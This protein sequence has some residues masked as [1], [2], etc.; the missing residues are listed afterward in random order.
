[1][2]TF[3]DIALVGGDAAA[4]CVL[5]CERRHVTGPEV[6]AT[7]CDKCDKTAAEIDAL[8]CDVCEKVGVK[9]D[10]F[11]GERLCAECIAVELE[12]DATDAENAVE[13]QR[14]ADLAS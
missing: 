2:A 7:Q 12:D 14:V 11:R 9:T 3:H 13:A 1:M 5:C 8:T 6:N 10:V 4:Y